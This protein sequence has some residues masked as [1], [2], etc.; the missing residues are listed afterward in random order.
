M[1]TVMV[2]DDIDVMRDVLARLLRREGYR[3]LTAGSGQEAMDVLAHSDDPGKTPPDLILLDVKM[4]DI[5]GLELL[6]RLHADMRWRNTP[7]V[8][9]SAISDTHAVH[10]AEQLGAKAYLV[11]STFSVG[12]MMSQVKKYTG[13][14]PH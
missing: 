12:E 7:V 9:L 11:K 4:P 5:D 6:E 3:T 2:V 8:M 13:Y 10:R 1:P 14:L